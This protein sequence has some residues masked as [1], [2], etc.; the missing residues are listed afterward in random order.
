MTCLKSQQ[1][2]IVCIFKKAVMYIHMDKEYC[3]PICD[4]I[5]SGKNLDIPKDGI[6]YIHHSENLNKHG[7][8][9]HIS[10]TSGNTSV[11]YMYFISCYKYVGIYRQNQNLKDIQNTSEHTTGLY[12][13]YLRISQCSIYLIS[14]KNN[15]VCW[16]GN[17][18]EEN[19]CD[20]QYLSGRTEENQ[21][22]IS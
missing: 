2:P 20:L 12:M 9:K 22:Q 13:G 14:D 21:K 5:F 7:S 6:L 4:A 16:T 10:K 8:S 1:N 17:D 18:S 15:H 19:F 11:R 3:L